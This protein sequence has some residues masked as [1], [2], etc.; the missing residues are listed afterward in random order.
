MRRPF[1]SKNAR[2]YTHCQ[3]IGSYVPLWHCAASS[4]PPSST[5]VGQ[6]AAPSV[7]SPVSSFKKQKRAFAMSSR[8]SR[9]ACVSRQSASARGTSSLSRK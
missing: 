7:N 1:S 2:R 9:A 5:S 4:A 3:T 6:M 8:F